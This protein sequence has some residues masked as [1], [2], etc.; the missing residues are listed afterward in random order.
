M[1]EVV[2][3]RTALAALFLAIVSVDASPQVAATQAAA[4]PARLFDYDANAPLGVE[5]RSK[6]AVGPVSVYDISFVSP[7]GGRVT[8]YL[9]VP[10]GDGPFAAILFVH[11]GQGDRTEFLSEA[12]RM[13]ERGAVS[14][15]IDGPFVRPDAERG[16]NML[17][18]E[19]ERDQWVKG[20]VEM[21]RAIDVLAARKDVDARRIGYVG[22]SYGATFGGVLAGVEKRIKAYAL[23]GGLPSLTIFDDPVWGSFWKDYTSEQK[24]KYA[25]VIRPIEP[26]RFVGNSS[27][28]SLLFQFAYHDRFIS[29]QAA[30]QFF[31]AAGQPKQ[32]KW[33]YCSHEFNDPQSPVDRAEWLSQQL[34]LKTRTA[35]PQRQ[36]SK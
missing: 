3:I 25:E 11:W 26:V 22:H 7:K 28:A 18:P 10:P 21:R 32:I 35:T 33:Y 2:V 6:H 8:S 29:E 15:L 19:R 17:N 5:Q 16:A 13:A 4:T 1:C 36:R 24:Q 27:P 23:M 31:E 30:K 14:L 20:V 34:G 12:V 9:V